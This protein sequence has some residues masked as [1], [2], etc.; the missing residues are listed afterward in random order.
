MI[1]SLDHWSAQA[2][3][4]F[5][6]AH[7]WLTPVVI[8][9]TAVCIFACPVAYLV[10]GWWTRTLRPGVA[11]LVALGLTQWASHEVGRLVYVARPFV[12]MHFTPLY[13]HPPNNS[14]PSTLT[15]FAAVAAV[16]A[17]LAWRRRGL[18]FVAGTAIIAFGCMYAGVH[19]L[20]DVIVGAAVGAACGAVTWI[21]AGIPPLGRAFSAIERRLPRRTPARHAPGGRR[22][23]EAA[24]PKAAPSSPPS[25]RRARQDP[26]AATSSSWRYP[27][28][29]STPYSGF[30]FVSSEAASSQPSSSIPRIS[31]AARRRWLKARSHASA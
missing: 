9:V 27:S 17:V 22:S 19:Y 3:H 11:A 29:M 13:P 6:I 10:V 7:A 16:V 5:A 21:I 14:F 20:S 2:L 31:P 24:S 26:S 12:A 25:L 28:A 1:P 8:V 18:V 4:A 23:A 15:A 30:C